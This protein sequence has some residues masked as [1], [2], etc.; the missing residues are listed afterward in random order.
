MEM[1]LIES[2]YIIINMVALIINYLETY[3]SFNKAVCKYRNTV[4]YI[5]Y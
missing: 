3:F 1:M 2:R 4:I 5:N